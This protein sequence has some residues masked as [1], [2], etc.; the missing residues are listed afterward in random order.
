MMARVSSPSDFTSINPNYVEGRGFYTTHTDISNLLQ[1]SAFSGSTTPNLIEVGKIIKNVEGRIDDTMGI[2]HRPIIFKHEYHNFEAFSMGSYPIQH[3]K[4]YV[5][6]VQLDQHKVQKILRLEVWQ[7]RE[8]KDLASATAKIT[9]P[10]NPANSTW[11]I[12]L[13]AGS[14]TFSIV[15]G[16]SDT[17]DFYD[18]FGP[19]TTASQLVDTINEVF[20]AKTAKFTGETAAKSLTANGN[21]D[22]NISDF[23]YATVDSEDSSTVIISSLLLGDDGKN[24][25]IS[26]NFGTVE[27]FADNENSGRTDD[28]WQIGDEGKIFFLRNYPHINSHSVRVTYVSGD[29][30]VTSAVH[31]AATKLAAAGILL[32]DDNSILIAE[33][34][35]NIDLKTKHDILVEEA[36]KI[37]DGK[38]KLIH[39]I[40]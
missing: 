32:H 4:D 6:F 37:L 22:I 40:S 16:T 2:S 34:G 11:T 14:F 20:P 13:V 19:K 7:G 3:Y 38:K 25:T 5:G 15:S 33:S 9:M 23:F 18:T 1:I 24:C 31:E 27:G 35:S 36:N 29:G 28:F 10:T 21:T 17:K 26:S 30:R 8:W 12:N 39:F